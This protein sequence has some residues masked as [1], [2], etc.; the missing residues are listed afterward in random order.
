MCV[1]RDRTLATTTRKPL[2]IGEDDINIPLLTLD[3]FETEPISSCIGAQLGSTLLCNSETRTTLAR[4]CIEKVKLSL[5]AARVMTQTY[6]VI[7]HAT[8]TTDTV[9]LSWPKRDSHA[10][11]EAVKLHHDL[12]QWQ[13]SLPKDCVFSA[14]LSENVADVRV[15]HVHRAVLHMFSLITAG[16]LYYPYLRTRT[17]SPSLNL[18]LENTV[19]PHLEKI[20]SVAS[21]MAEL[22]LRQDLVRYLPP[23]AVTF[24]LPPLVRLIGEIKC[25][26]HGFRD[27]LEYQF[28]QCNRA[29]LQLR[30][31]WPIA[32]SACVIVEGLLSRAQTAQVPSAISAVFLDQDRP[33]DQ[34]ST[35]DTNTQS[36]IPDD[37]VSTIETET[38]LPRQDTISSSGV[39]VG[40][41]IS[42]PTNVF[43]EI[44]WSDLEPWFDQNYSPTGDLLWMDLALMDYGSLDFTRPNR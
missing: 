40:E 39:A 2:R 31:T 27:K 14:N 13:S 30:E 5:Y 17:D 1:L 23:L 21:D 9:M 8:V 32:D 19:R 20:G 38:T 22:M 10:L 12:E 41:G 4:L 25:S 35:L 3:D 33:Q 16:V 28:R 42:F 34:A 6:T 37:L 26:R 44:V 29:I 18:F 24:F 43:D 7:G 36:V 15:L 11:S